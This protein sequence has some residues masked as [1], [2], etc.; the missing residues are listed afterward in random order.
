MCAN[1]TSHFTFLQ[2][3]RDFCVTLAGA[4]AGDDL[5]MMV[6][7]WDVVLRGPAEAIVATYKRVVGGK[8]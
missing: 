3:L 8:R 5:V 1:F 6:D 4:G 2:S 7:A